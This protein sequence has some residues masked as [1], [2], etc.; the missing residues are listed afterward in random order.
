MPQ[1]KIVFSRA[2]DEC[3]QTWRAREAAID[4]CTPELESSTSTHN[5]Q[6][7]E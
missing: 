7:E 2:L 6:T 4:H 3:R 1:K 5:S